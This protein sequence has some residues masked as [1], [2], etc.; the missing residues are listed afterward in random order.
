MKITK[1]QPKHFN[2]EA[3]QVSAYLQNH[4]NSKWLSFLWKLH[5]KKTKIRRTNSWQV[6]LLALNFL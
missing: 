4:I 6:I 2:F 3:S 5:R 1:A